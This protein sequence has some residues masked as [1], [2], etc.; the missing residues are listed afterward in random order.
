[1]GIIIMSGVV[2]DN[3]VVLFWGNVID[4]IDVFG[5]EI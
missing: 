2:I 3:I 5:V 4:N 1:M